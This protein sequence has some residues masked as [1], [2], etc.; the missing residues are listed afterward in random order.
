MTAPGYHIPV[1]ASEIA[2]AARGAQRVVDATI[3]GGGHAEL[4]R[5]QG[6]E[7]LGIDRDP[8]ALA[9]ARARLGGERI[10][11]LLAPYASVEALA[12][13]AAFQPDAILLDLGVSSHQLNQAD[14]G[15]SFR[16]GA[17]LDMRMSQT[18][19][20]GADLLNDT[21]VD[22]LRT[23]FAELGDE[24][25][26]AKLAREVARRRATLPFTSS[27][28]FVN[29]IRAVLGPRSGPGDFARLFQAI[30][31][32]VNGELD[33][34]R[35]ALPAFLEALRPGGC[36]AVISYHSGEDR[37]VKGAFRDWGAGCVCPSGLP[38]CICHRVPL[39]RAEPRKAVVS[40]VAELAANP[41]SRSARLRFFRIN[42]AG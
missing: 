20:T 29:A 13:V 37:L 21:S 34:L 27:D 7:I 24:R 12:A 14:R 36:L 4:L 32:A 6:A 35:T 15:F 8:D 40:S 31:I 30:R 18:G 39:G 22:E 33:G 3:G 16:P 25:H 38:Q 9:A 41:R 28:D 17:P 26:S 10:S 19:P 1:L 23:L 11:Y 5:A 2:A 42:D